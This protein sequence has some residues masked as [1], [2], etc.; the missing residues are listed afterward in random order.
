[1]KASRIKTGCV[2]PASVDIDPIE[3]QT[4]LCFRGPDAS[5]STATDERSGKDRH[6]TRIECDVDMVIDSIFARSQRGACGAAIL[7]MLV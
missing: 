3:N 2:S 4:A 7:L 5:A 6:S 1:V